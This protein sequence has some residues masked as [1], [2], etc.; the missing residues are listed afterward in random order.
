MLHLSYILHE[1][2]SATA[3]V[4]S[5]DRNLDIIGVSFLSDA[6]GD[7]ARAARGTLRGMPNRSS[8]SRWSRVSDRFVVSRDG[9]QVFV[10]VYY[11]V[12]S[13]SRRRDGELVLTAEC[14]LR[15]FA[16]EHQLSAPSSGRARRSGVSRA[17]EE[18]GLPAARISR[19]PGIA[20]RA[21]GGPASEL[22][23]CTGPRP[24]NVY[25]N[26]NGRRRCRGQ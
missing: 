16:T 15:E 18:C 2:G 7:M 5:G 17:M 6:L 20:A 22:T 13:F 11:L 12:E 23:R 3:S 19:S 25:C 9:T 14:N 4:G 26:P 21:F 10:R 8:A 1:D 24:R